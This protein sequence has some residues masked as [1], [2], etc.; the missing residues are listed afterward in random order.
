MSA[1]LGLWIILEPGKMGGLNLRFFWGRVPPIDH[2]LLLIGGGLKA[3]SP[4][5][6]Y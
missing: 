3:M 1:N 6:Y 2:P 5:P 4:F